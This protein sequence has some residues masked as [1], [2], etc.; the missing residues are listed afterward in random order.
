M[1][2]EIFLGG[3]GNEEAS[4]AVDNKFI[5]TISKKGIEK[6]I[7]IP[8]AM[9]SIPYPKCLEWFTSVFGKRMSDIEMWDSLEGQRLAGL[10]EKVSIYIGGG[11]TVK[12]LNLFKTTGFDN[13]LK[14]FSNSGGVIYGGSAGAIV[15][16][17]DISPAPESKNTKD[18]QGLGLLQDYSISCHFKN[19]QSVLVKKI[20]NLIGTPVIAIEENS[21]IV[22]EDGTISTLGQ[23]NSYIFP[24]GI[25]I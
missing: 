10:E 11:N 18:T 17:K 12:L 23:G 22:Y 5:E 15:L 21:G 9:E 2:G 13:K 8:I 1:S 6:I 4:K 25:R 20:A 19:G 7:Y 14:K 16:G 24:S 3:G